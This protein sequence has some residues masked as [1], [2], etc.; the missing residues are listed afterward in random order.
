MPK[1]M[2]DLKQIEMIEFK[3]GLLIVLRHQRI[4]CSQWPT[5]AFHNFVNFFKFAPLTNYKS[6]IV[7]EF[8]NIQSNYTNTLTRHIY[9]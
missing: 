3:N 9:L 6:C 1:P 8:I 4:A 2:Q 7:D 5:S